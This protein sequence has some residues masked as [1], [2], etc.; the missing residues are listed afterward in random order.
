[1]NNNTKKLYKSTNDVW[2]A[3]VMSGIAEYFSIDPTVLRLGYIL[4]LLITG[5]FPGV[6][7]YIIAYFVIPDRPTGSKQI[8]DNS[9]RPKEPASAKGSSEV[10]KE[11][12]IVTPAPK[13]SLTTGI[14]NTIKIAAAGKVKN[15][16]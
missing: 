8:I 13:T 15:N 1:M 5:I 9:S 6:V 12:V 10:R 14:L 3:G 2:I 7:A 16:I 11:S 4:L